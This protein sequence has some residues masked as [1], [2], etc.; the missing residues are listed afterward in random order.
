VDRLLQSRCART[1]PPGSNR[2]GAVFEIRVTPVKGNAVQACHGDTGEHQSAEYWTS[3]PS[4]SSAAW[5]LCIAFTQERIQLTIQPNFHYTKNMGGYYSDTHPKI[6]QMQIELIR[7]MPS[8]EK[9]AAIDDLNETVKS[10]ALSGIMQRHPDA[11]T[12]QIKRMLADILLGQDLAQ[13]AYDH[14]R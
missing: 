9:F 13:K 7:K 11:T 5:W 1:A 14:A 4:V 3:V 12:V 10:L 2:F 6:E 8:W